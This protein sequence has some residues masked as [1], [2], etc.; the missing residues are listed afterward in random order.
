MATTSTTDGKTVRGPSMRIL[1]RDTTHAALREVGGIE[2]TPAKR[3]KLMRLGSG[4]G[5]GY[6]AM[7]YLRLKT[8]RCHQR[9]Y[10]S[11]DAHRR[12][13]FLAPR[14]HGKSI[15]VGRVLVGHR[16]LTNRNIRILIVSRTKGAAS[17]T[18]RLVRQDFERNR[19]IIE[20]WTTD[21]AGGAFRDKGLPWTDSLFYVARPKA[22]RDPT[23]EC[24]GVGGSI[25]GG[26]FDLIIIDDPEDDKSVLTARQ[27]QKTVDWLRGTILEL[28]D[29]NGRVVV[30]GTKKHAGD[31]YATLE[32]DPTF[33][34]LRDQ[35]F[36]E[37][38]DLAK[39]QWVEREDPET[40]RVVLEDVV[41]PD[42]AGGKA[43]WPEK[44]PVKE[45]LKKYRSLGSVM[46]RRENQN[47]ITDDGA[48]PFR[49]G[50]LDAAK[51]RGA[52]LGFLTR[53]W[54]PEKDRAHP[55]CEGLYVW[56]S[57]DCAL[58][59]DAEKA[60]EADSDYTVIQTWG[61]DWR[62]GHRTLL[63]MVRRRGLTQGELMGLLESE[64]ALFPQSLAL[65][66]EANA[67][68]K[69][70]IAGLRKSTALPIQKHVT[71]KK[72]H[73]YFEGV[74]AMSVD[75]ENG[76]ITLP[77]G[78]PAELGPGEEDPRVL[79]DTLCQE[80]HG[81]GKETHDD[82]VMCAWIGDVWI[83]RFI[84]AEEHRRKTFKQKCD[85]RPQ[86]PG[87]PDRF[88]PLAA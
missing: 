60:Q 10:E 23:L 78:R 25:T 63:R 43:L 47:E 74:P 17:K 14:S 12:L 53:G 72:K 65:V 73:S 76:K 1:K 50:W 45:L 16:I 21:D 20:D 11:F 79:V 46:F 31:L 49:K 86:K 51:K 54:E 2:S 55:R 9:W 80:L 39:V 22:A 69:L 81:V 52:R 38:P 29:T 66:I 18:V 33:A 70:I 34:L 88:I 19:R 57:A 7:R 27:R 41:V 35:A 4:V 15:T 62:T 84:I 48:S 83:R 6:Y 58:N 13:L 75:Y 37:W 67:F 71:D 28:L 61:L 5:L 56:Q 59:D 24:V 64:A 44:W 3:R 85:W 40:G 8:P 82:T 87:Q 36:V 26:R 32:Q 30:I 77:T 42:D 68:Q